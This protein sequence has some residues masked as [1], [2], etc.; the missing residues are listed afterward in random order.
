MSSI[1]VIGG[2]AIDTVDHCKGLGPKEYFGGCGGNIAMGLAK[3]FG[4]KTEIALAT[5]TSSEMKDRGYIQSLN[6][7]GVNTDLVCFD[8]S[9]QCRV[10]EYNFANPDEGRRVSSVAYSAD[11]SSF[12][13]VNFSDFDTLVLSVDNPIIVRY[14]LG[15]MEK[16]AKRF[17]FDLSNSVARLTREE[18]ARVL[19]QVDRLY[20][21]D[22]EAARFISMFD[23]QSILDC[24]SLMREN[25]SITVTEGV[26]G[27]YTVGID[28]YVYV[29]ALKIR[30]QGVDTI[31]CGDAFR[32]AHLHQ[33]VSS[34]NEFEALKCGNK[35]GAEAYRFAGGQ[36]YLGEMKD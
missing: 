10:A 3:Q 29:K 23:R 33:F 2:L 30:G 32:T 12:P 31:G 20:M 14:F 22:H 19:G 1:L 11:V 16:A 4:A 15:E 13:R 35:M 36:G 26:S 9:Q 21:N 28:R 5:V 27:A 6:N 17:V 34:G 7:A 18:I 24:S 25:N 8:P